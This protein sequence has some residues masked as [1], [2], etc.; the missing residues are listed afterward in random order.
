MTYEQ[1]K[2]TLQN[3]KAQHT[4]GPWFF[5]VDPR[6]GLRHVFTAYAGNPKTGPLKQLAAFEVYAHERRNQ[7]DDKTIAALDE[8][9]ANARLI[10]AA[11]E[12]LEAL[13]WAILTLDAMAGVAKAGKVAELGIGHFQRVTKARAAIA[14]AEGK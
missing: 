9:E 11:P 5:H 1:A 10:A 4:P 12:L 2:A 3:V 8:A 6:L 7:N 13:N 14:K